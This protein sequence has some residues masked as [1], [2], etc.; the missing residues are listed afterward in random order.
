MLKMNNMNL[1]YFY[2]DV[3]SYQRNT[4][5]IQKNGF[6][7]INADSPESAHALMETKKVDLAIMDYHALNHKG[8]EPLR[9]LRQKEAHIPVIITASHTDKESLLDTINLGVTRFLTK[10]TRKNELVEALNISVKKLLEQNL[11]TYT[12]L[13]AQIQ[14]DPVNKIIIHPERGS[15]Q[16]SKKESLLIELYINNKDKIVPYK[17]IENNVWQGSS[18]S[19]DALRTLIYSIRKKT[20]PQFLSN[21]NTIGYKM[22]FRQ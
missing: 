4:P 10:P 1:L 22:D 19:L 20:S 9:Y 11:V 15:I 7:I 16:L 17:T 8:L 6:N 21:I 13:S 14:Y 5:L 3:K 12:D 18:M 2:D